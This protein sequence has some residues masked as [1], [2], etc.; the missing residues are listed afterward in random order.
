[1]R[2]AALLLA[3]LALL[4]ASGAGAAD[5]GALLDSVVET[6][7]GPS[8]AA[9]MQALRVEAEV[10]AGPGRGTG[11]VV[12]DFLA[13]DRLRVEIAYPRSTEVRTLE[14]GKGWRGDD[15]RL[16]RVE[17]PPRLAMEYQLLRSAV[18][19]VFV[20]HRKRFEDRGEASREGGAYR[21]V[22]LPWSMDLDL[23]YWIDTVSRRVVWVEGVLRS[24][25]TQIAFLTQYRDFRRV[26]GLLV[27]FAEESF[28]GGRRTGTTRV[29][30]VAFSPPDLGPF[31]PTRLKR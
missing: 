7:G 6:Y 5:L 28:A 13:P 8:A 25:G 4:L 17:G 30:A 29:T 20:H 12:R 18:P 16:Q 22:G 3:A 31:D 1:V 14:G 23:T 21:R 26:E 10:E 9:K 11:R 19:W 2:R 27:P 15:G 24:P